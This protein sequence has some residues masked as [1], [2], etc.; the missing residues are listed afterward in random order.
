[1]KLKA[2]LASNCQVQET[3][4]TN[5][6]FLFSTLS[7]ALAGILKTVIHSFIAASVVAN[8]KPA[9]P[10]PAPDVSPEEAEP[11]STF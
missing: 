7:A 10:M 1:L 5:H 11:E 9:V 2:D 8:G 6:S 3:M 4:Q